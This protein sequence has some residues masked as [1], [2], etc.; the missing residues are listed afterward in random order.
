MHA[1]EGWFFPSLPDNVSQIFG[2]MSNRE[3]SVW[4]PLLAFAVAPAVCEELA[5]RGFILSGMQRSGRRWLPIVMS[6]VAFGIVH[7]ISQQVFN[8]ILLGLV[9]GLLAVRSRSLIP[10]IVFHFLF[11]GTQVLLSRSDLKAFEHEG[12]KWLITVERAGAQAQLR[13]EWPL[14]IVCA[15][16]AA[17]L[18]RWLAVKDAQSSA[19]THPVEA[20]QDWPS[21][22]VGRDTV[23]V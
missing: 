4:R 13:Y 9:L 1:L 3:I 8:A 10:C 6:S 15:V 21:R 2:A 14:L 23:R 5:F 12:L 16:A 20:P 7:L 22:E 18:I 19:E 17:V 11:N